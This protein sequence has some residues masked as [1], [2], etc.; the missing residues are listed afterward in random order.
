MVF[1]KKLLLYY[2]NELRST[3]STLEIKKIQAS[4][5]KVYNGP[6]N[7]PIK[8]TP[9]EIT[10]NKNHVAHNPAKYTKHEPETIRFHE[11]IKNTITE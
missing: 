5:E 9:V 1:I 11:E 7:N 2:E 10:I 3:T 6:I 4:F 8:R